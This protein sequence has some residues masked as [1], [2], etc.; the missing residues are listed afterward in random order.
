MESTDFTNNLKIWF[1]SVILGLIFF[2]HKIC[3]QLDYRSLKF[4]NS[5]ICFVLFLC[6]FWKEPYLLNLVPKKA[7]RLILWCAVFMSCDL[8]CRWYN[9]IVWF[10][11]D[12]LN[13]NFLNRIGVETQPDPS[14]GG[15]LLPILTA[16]KRVLT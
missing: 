1:E 2:S 9:T 3:S 7:T 13:I 4:E 14:V 12:T 6:R 16:R 10:I 8:L 15:Y 5:L 11:K